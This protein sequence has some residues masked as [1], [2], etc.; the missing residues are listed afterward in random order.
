MNTSARVLIIH[1]WGS[2]SREHWFLE[3][4]T[5]L[6][7][8]GF[9]VLVP[10]MPDTE[11]PKQD[12]WVKII[13]QFSPDENSI[14]IGHSLGGAAILR[15]LEKAIQK[16]GQSIFVATPV[17]K[18]GIGVIDDFFEPDFNWAKIKAICGCFAIFNQTS[19]PWVP[20]SHGHNLAQHTAGELV[21]FEGADHF[22]TIDFQLLEKHILEK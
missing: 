20:L 6:E 4:K 12:E 14:L 8:K 15:Y 11:N 21:V 9:Q 5:R 16:V 19:D 2:N 3:E 22:D 10:D 18:L 13:E 17:E 1:G 7:A